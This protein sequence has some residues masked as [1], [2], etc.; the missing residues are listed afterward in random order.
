MPFA[1]YDSNGILIGGLAHRWFTLKS[2]KWKPTVMERERY[3]VKD[4]AGYFGRFTVSQITDDHVETWA[5]Q[6]AAGCAAVTFN[7][8]LIRLNEIFNYAV[9][10]GYRFDNPAQ[11]IEKR[12]TVKY[13]PTIPSRTEFANILAIMRSN[14]SKPTASASADLCEGLTYLGCRKADAAWLEWQHID[15]KIGT[16]RI[17]G[18]P[19][20]HTKNGEQ[21][22]IPL[23]DPLRRLLLDMRAAL[24]A[25]PQPTDKVFMVKS[26]RKAFE[27][28]CQQ[29]GLPH[30]PPH[31]T[32]R[33]FFISHCIMAGID[34]ETI[35]P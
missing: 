9:C 3:T 32:W 17:T 19:L 10:K 27:T 12:P 6:R 24:P 20:T 25:P 5:K 18:H 22:I 26:C 16:V 13:V 23:F 2:L 4:L 11:Y 34:A 7:R 21:R 31:H 33:R 15:F 14:K 29:L 30:Y 35:A 8:D 28:A 1:E